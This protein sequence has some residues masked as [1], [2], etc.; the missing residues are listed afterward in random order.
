MLL[1]SAT[2]V[3][4]DIGSSFS[5]QQTV[6]RLD[7]TLEDTLS[8]PEP[9]VKFIGQFITHIPR[10]SARRTKFRRHHSWKK[11]KSCSLTRLPGWRDAIT[12]YL[13]LVI[14]TKQKF[15][16]CSSW[17]WKSYNKLLMGFLSYKYPNFFQNGTLNIVSSRGE[18]NIPPCTAE[19]QESKK[20]VLSAQPFCENIKRTM[21]AELAWPNYLPNAPPP[22]TITLA[23]K[24]QHKVGRRQTFK[25]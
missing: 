13:T 5:Y 22:N 23:I 17:G 25:L 16:S 7:N 12:K 21:R 2:V 3:P 10:S 18:R 6:W 9:K 14:H 15:I 24:V 4:L 19:E 1:I 11:R 20:Q 8:W